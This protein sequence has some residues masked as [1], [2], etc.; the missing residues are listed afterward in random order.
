L[1]ESTPRILKGKYK[2]EFHAPSTEENLKDTFSDESKAFPKYIVFAKNAEQE[3]LKSIARL[4]RATTQAKRL[5][6][7]EH[8]QDHK[9]LKPTLSSLCYKV[10]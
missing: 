1:I 9:I 8:L 2:K 7:R 4:F 10:K 5:H 6:A 3:G